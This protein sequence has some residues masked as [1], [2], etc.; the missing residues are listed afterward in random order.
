LNCAFAKITGRALKNIPDP[1]MA[2]STWLTGGRRKNQPQMD[3]DTSQIYTDKNQN[4]NIC[5]PSVSHLWQKI[6]L[7]AEAKIAS[8]AKYAPSQ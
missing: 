4:L 7:P 8:V 2:K 1:Q 5:V 6:K 3:T